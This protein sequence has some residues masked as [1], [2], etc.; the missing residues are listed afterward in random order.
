MGLYGRLEDDGRVHRSLQALKDHFEVTIFA[1]CEKGTFSME[2][3]N[4]IERRVDI[5]ESNKLLEQLLYNLFFIR[6]ALSHKPDILYVHDYYLPLAARL[7]RIFRGTKVVYDAHEL[8]VPSPGKKMSVR[9]RYFYWFE[10][11]FIKKFDLVIAANEERAEYMQQWYKLKSKPLPILNI[12]DHVPLNS[13][14]SRDSIDVQIPQIAEIGS[15]QTIFVYQGVI[16]PLRRI[17]RVVEKVAKLPGAQIL[18]VGGGEREYLDQLKSGFEEQGLSNVHFLG[19]VD[20][21]VLYS[22]L[23]IADYGLIAY[24]N[25]DLN[26]RFCA[27]NKL[28][29]Y[30]YFDLP[31]VTSEQELFVKTFKSYPFGVVISEEQEVFEAAFKEL[32]RNIEGMG[33]VFESFRERYNVENEKN[34]LRQ[35]V[36]Q[37]NN[38]RG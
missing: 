27:P 9:E 7:I 2:G 4:V 26:N 24:D 15:A 6:A 1:H 33:R 5:F 16:V 22:I 11:L 30:A 37:L 12:V 31:M 35:A 23:N 19:K 20:L 3:V 28:Y 17:D 32:E 36:M 8:M 34:K 18:L 29:E 10:R 25:F 38:N 21:K 13:L 14:L